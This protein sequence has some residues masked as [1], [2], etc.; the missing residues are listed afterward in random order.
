MVIGN[1][2]V[3]INS[4]IK[5]RMEQLKL[6]QIAKQIHKRRYKSIRQKCYNP[7]FVLQL[8]HS[9]HKARMTQ[10]L[11]YL[12]QPAYRF[13]KEKQKEIKNKSGKQF[14][15]RKLNAFIALLF[16][17]FEL[18]KKARPRLRNIVA[19]IQSGIYGPNKGKFTAKIRKQVEKMLLLEG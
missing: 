2:T 11:P 14:E 7:L 18:K 8:Y 9:L 5:L 19:I 16:E 13:L 15:N 17:F 6:H 10:H 1:I 3:A 12:L 4:R